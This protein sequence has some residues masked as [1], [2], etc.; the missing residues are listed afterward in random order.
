VTDRR[1]NAVAVFAIVLAA[2]AL[3]PLETRA[4]FVLMALAVATIL[5]LLTVRLRAHAAKRRNAR[6]DGTYERI[7]RIRAARNKPRR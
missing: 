2:S 1:Q 5:V 7:E 6:V 3:L 4:R